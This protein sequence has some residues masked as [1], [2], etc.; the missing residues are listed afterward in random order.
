MSL[1]SVKG[2]DKVKF[3]VKKAFEGTLSNSSLQSEV[4]TYA[5]GQMKLYARK[6]TP[7][8]GRNVGSFPSG[9]P[10]PK[11]Q[12]QRERLAKYNRTHPAYG[13]STP[14]LT[15]TGQLIDAI[16]Y[17][18][19]KTKKGLFIEFFVDGKRKPYMTGRNKRQKPTKINT[20]NAEL[21]KL[22]IDIDK[23][24]AILG[25]GPIQRKVITNKVRSFL[26]RALGFTK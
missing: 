16:K 15:I 1:A 7:L 6:A 12:E 24:F 20:D 18:F 4:G 5:V 26:R 23:D 2:V 22:L 8:Q 13:R 19:S 10:R 14:N 25:L 17:E 9:Y 3:S 21:Y 11:T